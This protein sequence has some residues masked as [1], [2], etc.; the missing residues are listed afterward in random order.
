MEA[1]E[2]GVRES[3]IRN[4]KVMVTL[5]EI[6]EAEGVEV[7]EED[8]EKEAE[9]MSRAMGMEAE[10]IAKYITLSGQRGNYADRILR[11]KTLDV[12]L[13]IANVTDTELSRDEMD[14]EDSDGEN[15]GE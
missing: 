9:T 7:T 10:R 11:G 13:E 4:I 1:I 8:F 14:K 12:I 2:S 3:V 5:Y 6:A 15:T